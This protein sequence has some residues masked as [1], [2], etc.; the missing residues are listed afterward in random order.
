MSGEDDNPTVTVGDV[1]DM[2]AQGQNTNAMDAINTMLDNRRDAAMGQRAIDIAN[3]VWND[4][5]DQQQSEEPEAQVDDGES[6]STDGDE[7][8]TDD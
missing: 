1:V 4:V 8:S 2:V 3:S 6:E 5:P 7:E